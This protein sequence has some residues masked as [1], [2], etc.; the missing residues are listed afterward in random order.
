MESKSS[1]LR[2]HI[3]EVIDRMIVG[4]GSGQH[5]SIPKFDYYAIDYLDFAHL[6]LDSYLSISDSLRKDNELISCVSNLKRAVDNQIE[7]F[8][9]SW[10]L[11]EDTKKRNLGLDTKLSFLAEVGI[12]RSR[13]IQRFSSIRNKVEHGF[14]RPEIGDLEAMFDLVTALVALLQNNM[15]SGHD[16]EL[17]CAV[18]NKDDTK[19]VE[20]FEL[21]YDFDSLEI[22][23]S[24]ELRENRSDITTVS[25]GLSEFKDF[26]YFFR[27]L[28]L[29]NQLDTF[30]SRT[31]VKRLLA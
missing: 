29:L 27:V 11:R 6:N 17:N 5:R 16:S 14:Q 1:I 18:Y 9:E 7:C 30:A 8:L 2:E 3:L 21:I 13:T 10:G 28:L 31:H 24:W 15:A 25:A 20:V 19:E 12:I 26:A 4:S 23:A 22:I